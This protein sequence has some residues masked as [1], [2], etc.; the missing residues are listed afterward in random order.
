MDRISELPKDILQRILYFLSQKESIR[1]SVLSKS[2][3]TIWR[4]RPNLDLDFSDP[5][6]IDTTR[7]FISVVDKT[8]QL[9]RDQT[10]RLEEF[11]LSIPLHCGAHC[12]SVSLLVKWIPL[13]TSMGVKEFFLSI[14]S[15]P[16]DP[17]CLDLPSVVFEAAESLKHL[18]VER[19]VFDE[20]AE[21]IALCKHLRSLHL[22]NVSVDDRIF[23]TIISGCPLIETLCI[24][25]TNIG[26]R[27]IKMSDLR[28]LKDFTFIE[29]VFGGGDQL[30]SIEID[31]LS[32]ET[33]KISAANITFRRGADF[34]NLKD[35]YMCGVKSSLDNLSFSKLPSLKRLTLSNCDGL[36]ESRI[37]IDAPN[38][39][40]FEYEGDFVP[41]V[42]IVTNS[43]EW[44]SEI[45]LQHKNDGSSL[46]F[47]KLS[48]L[49]KSLSQS[50]I[51]LSIY[52]HPYCKDDVIQE[53]V[54]R[55][56]VH[57]KPVLV[58][59]FNL[60]CPLSHFPTLVNGVFSICRPGNIGNRLKG[61]EVDYDAYIWRGREVKFV[62]YMWKILM[63]RESGNEDDEPSRLFLRDLEE[64]SLEI[65]RKRGN[66]PDED[67]WHRAPLSEYLLNIEKNNC[68]FVLKWRETI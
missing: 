50:K 16:Y 27:T 2:W 36:K 59:T 32:L 21:K 9:Y 4:T 68:R 25:G 6:L 10:L 44:K 60:V 41:S 47:L 3:R 40:Y 62:G 7:E 20:K 30:C 35:L 14:R 51:S 49:L 1:T 65:K 33:I 11:R 19:F 58:E 66:Y 17:G 48:E 8:L 52:K 54:N 57:D 34:R 38:V 24:D 42:S 31:P 12:K 37:F 23:Q 53:N 63:E 5:T 39:L 26:L 43:R 61:W 28:N 46:W 13:L 67:E 15:V 45:H 55:P 22:V 56:P 18:R 64:A 29:V